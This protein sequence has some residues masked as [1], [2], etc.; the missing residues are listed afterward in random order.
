MTKSYLNS[1]FFVLHHSLFI[2]KGAAS[3]QGTPL[4]GTPLRDV[5]FV[6]VPTDWI[7]VDIFQMLLVILAVTDDVIIKMPLPNIFAVLF[8]TKSFKCRHKA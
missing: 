3:L 6:I 8:I 4:D 1:S 5:G 7:F 2:K